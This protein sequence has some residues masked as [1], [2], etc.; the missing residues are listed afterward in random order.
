M[1]DT[2]NVSPYLLREPVTEREDRLLR[3]VRDY[4]S[5]WENP[6]PDGVYR[7]WLRDHMFAC[8][9]AYRSKP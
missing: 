5:E 3:A 2:P 1:T 8:L 9:D 7:R 4:R 6:V